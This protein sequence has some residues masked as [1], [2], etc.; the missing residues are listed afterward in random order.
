MDGGGDTTLPQPQPSSSPAIHGCLQQFR[1]TKGHGP[2]EVV[3]GSPVPVPHLHAEPALYIPRLEV[4]AAGEGQG[5]GWLFL[6]L[7]PPL[8]LRRSLPTLAGGAH[9][10]LQGSK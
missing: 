5:E 2:H 7:Q 8:P 3:A 4:A 10:N 9:V 6:P 1:D